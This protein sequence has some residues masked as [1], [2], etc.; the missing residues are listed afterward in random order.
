MQD[1]EN[2]DKLNLPPTHTAVPEET[3]WIKSLLLSLPSTL[4][5][6][7]LKDTALN[8]GTISLPYSSILL[9]IATIATVWDKVQD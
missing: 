1:F 4:F 8:S 6:F 3:G 5:S 9:Y 7:K 2:S